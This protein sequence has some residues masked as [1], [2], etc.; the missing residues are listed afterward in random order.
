MSVSSRTPRDIVMT[1]HAERVCALQS[2]EMK[3]C[4]AKRGVDAQITLLKRAP[5][6]VCG[7]NT[8]V[9]TVADSFPQTDR[10]KTFLG[11]VVA[12]ITRSLPPRIPPE[13]FKGGGVAAS[14][15][16]AN[17]R[18]PATATPQLPRGQD[19]PDRLLGDTEFHRLRIDRSDHGIQG[20]ET[21]M[22]FAVPL[23]AGH[24]RR[25]LVA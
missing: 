1:P 16:L 4:Y 6:S 10:W 22:N 18:L 9:R 12:R 5:E 2:P 13:R 20:I 21:L 15:G 17:C 7:G 25:R 8:H 24:G 14:L 3:E 19:I 23:D 11:D